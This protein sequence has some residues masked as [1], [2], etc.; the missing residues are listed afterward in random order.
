MPRYPS[1]SVGS[2]PPLALVVTSHPATRR[3]VASA[4]AAL[5]FHGLDATSAADAL[6][7]LECGPHLLVTD[8]PLLLPDGRSLLD[9][10]LQAAGATGIG[11]LAFTAPGRRKE[12]ERAFDLGAR[13]LTHGAPAGRIAEELE[14]ALALPTSL[15]RRWDC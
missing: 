3:A 12:R 2:G 15:L 8:Y 7:L 14:S 11:I 9:A 4:L 10:A 13:T 1:P 5:G 6:P